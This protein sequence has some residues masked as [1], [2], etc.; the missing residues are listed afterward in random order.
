MTQRITHRTI[1]GVLYRCVD[2]GCDDLERAKR[3]R[4]IV[5]EGLFT[6][7]YQMMEASLSRTPLGT[8]IAKWIP[9][10]N[11]PEVSRQD[12]RQYGGEQGGLY[13]LDN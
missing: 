2:T 1:D 8:K 13:E 3:N 11:L 5:S 7:F 10:G 6:T 4:L 9:L 12:W